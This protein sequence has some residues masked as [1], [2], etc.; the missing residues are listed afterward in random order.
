MTR[1]IGGPLIHPPALY[2]AAGPGYCPAFQRRRGPAQR[3]HERALRQAD[4]GASE[5]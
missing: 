1:L 2:Q 5:I 3:Q 4:R